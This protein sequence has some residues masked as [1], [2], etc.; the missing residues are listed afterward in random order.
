MTDVSANR[1]SNDTEGSPI[2]FLGG[3]DKINRYTIAVTFGA[4]ASTFFSNTRFNFIPDSPW[5]SVFSALISVL[6]YGILFYPFFACLTTDNRLAG[7]LLGFLYVTMRFIVGLV[8]EFQCK[9]SYEEDIKTQQYTE[10][11]G[12][13]PTYLCLLFIALRFAMLVVLEIKQCR[14]L[15]NWVMLQYL[16]F[17]DFY[18]NRMF[19]SCVDE[20]L[21]QSFLPLLFRKEL[22]ILWIPDCFRFN[23]ILRFE[24]LLA[25]IAAI[26]SAIF[27]YIHFLIS[28]DMLELYEEIGKALARFYSIMSYFFFF[29]NILLGLFSSIMRILIGMLSGVIFISRI[30][31]TSLMQG[32]QT[33]DRAFVAYLG[34]IHVLVA[35]SHPVM[36][37][38]CQLLI[39]SNRDRQCDTVGGEGPGLCVQSSHPEDQRSSVG[40]P[41][42]RALRL[43]RMPHQAIN[44]WFL[45]VTL[46]RNPSLVKYR[47]QGA[48]EA[49]RCCVTLEDANCGSSTSI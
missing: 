21:C 14:V 16:S 8:I 15:S 37:M 1:S 45:T 47:R 22:V 2:N 49:K 40:H 42:T 12:E 43:P 33:W 31:R 36:L 10:F 34:F 46:L 11:L 20:P 26:L 9:E 6:E 19:S 30:D 4:T 13:V 41:Q 23:R 32:F 24:F 5:I 17:F 39:N 29:Y 25:I 27:K 35:H 3:M 7:S 28:P 44:R 48:R 38:F 18:K